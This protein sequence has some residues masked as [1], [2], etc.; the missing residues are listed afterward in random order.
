[1]SNKTD[2]LEADLLKKIDSTILSP[3]KTM[4]K[5]VSMQVDKTDRYPMN[6]GPFEL[7]SSSVGDQPLSSDKPHNLDES[8]LL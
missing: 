4:D 2:R 7:K 8:L 1:M 3:I 5:R 6:S